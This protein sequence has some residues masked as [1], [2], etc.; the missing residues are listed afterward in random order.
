LVFGEEREGVRKRGEV[1]RCRWGGEV[2]VGGEGRCGNGEVISVEER[3][4]VIRWWDA[5]AVK[6]RRG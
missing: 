5:H 1:V 2:G 4:G 3:G 6:V